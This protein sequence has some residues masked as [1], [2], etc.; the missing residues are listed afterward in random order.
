MMLAGV[1]MAASITM[2]VADSKPGGDPA[3]DQAL[4]K[5]MRHDYDEAVR[6]QRQEN[7]LADALRLLEQYDGSETVPENL[8]RQVL[9][10]RI[11]GTWA[12]RR[13]DE[14]LRLFHHSLDLTLP[15]GWSKE[16][17]VAYGPDERHLLDMYLPKGTRQPA[18]VLV[19]IHGGGWAHGSQTGYPVMRRDLVQ[20]V[21]ARG[22]A[23][24]SITYRY[25]HQEHRLPAPL[26]DSARAVQ[27]LRANAARYNLD[28]T[29]FVAIG[30][31]AGGCNTLWL[32]THDDLADPEAVDP[33]LRESTRLQG[34]VADSAQTTVDPADMQ[35]GDILRALD[36]AM[37]A[38]G[39]K[40]PKEKLKALDIDAETRKLIDYCSPV[41]HLDA[42]DPP[43]FLNYVGPLDR[44]DEGVHHPRLGL[45]F[46]KR[47]DA[48]GAR[49]TLSVRH[50]P[51]FP[52]AEPD[53]VLK[54]LGL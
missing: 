25:V 7:R 38:N 27:F 12:A 2:A 1:L 11:W 14:S 44:T 36:H 3:V 22:G 26:H 46:K 51:E 15:D 41:K 6:L 33:V 29:R 35:A 10:Y 53:S 39:L 43:I 52:N 18:P 40:V 45:L 32:A 49:C 31:S 28:K 48:V 50:E 24:A 16:L 13:F 17:N 4:E 42:G 20:K 47:A 23:V 34:A 54:L 30:D 37:F 8:R 21:L 5:Q 19:L 9:D